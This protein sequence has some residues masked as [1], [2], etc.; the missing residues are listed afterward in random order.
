MSK[1][2][3]RYTAAV[4]Y[5]RVAHADQRRK[6]SEIPY[7]YHLLAVSS[8]VLAHGGD[9]DQA[10]AGL[11]PDVLEDCGQHHEPILRSRFGDKVADIVLTCTDGTAEN[12]AQAA[13]REAKRADWR[14]RKLAYLAH[15]REASDAALL[16][17]GCDKCHNASAIVEDLEDPAV[18]IAVFDRFTASAAETLGYYHALSEVF[19]E[20]RSPVSRLFKSRVARMHELAGLAERRALS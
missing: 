3:E 11:L 9:E 10:I 16:V 2:T 8:L 1:L 20:R 12:K 19:A 7:L 6:G 15:L 4:D 17:S 18:G 5:A 14:Q 13:T